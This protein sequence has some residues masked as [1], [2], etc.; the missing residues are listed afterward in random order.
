MLALL[1]AVALH[2]GN[3]VTPKLHQSDA[4]PLED[5]LRPVTRI[6]PTS[7]TLRWFTQTATETRVEWREGD[8][9]RTAFRGNNP[10]RRYAF[11]IINGPAGTRTVHTLTIDGLKPATRYYYR[12]WDPGAKPTR[13]EANWGA[14]GG[15]RREF[16]VST[17]APRG[18]KAIIHLPVKVLLMPNVVDVH[19]AYADPANPAPFPPKAT[20]E[21]IQKMKDEFA[22]SSRF[23][24]VNSGMRFWV[25]YEFYIDER[26]QR[27][28]P[29]PAQASGPFKGL[30]VSRSY[31]GEDYKQPGGG[32]HTI[33]DTEDPLRVTNTPVVEAFPYS[34][35][36]EVAWLQRW[37]P[38][39]KRWEYSNSG[40]GTFGVDSFPQG[41][42]S[43]SQFLGGGDAAWLATHEV[44]HGFE[45]L[46]T[47]S[48]SDREDERIVFNH[49]APRRRV[50]KAEGQ[51]EEQ[52]W[53]TSGPHGEHWDGMAYWDRTLSDAQWLRLYFGRTIAVRDADQ[54]GVPDDDPRLPLDEKRF[55]SSPRRAM[56]DGRLN[57][58]Q[59][60]MLSTWVPGPL[61]SSWI[62]PPFQAILPKPTDPDSDGDGLNDDVDPQPLYPYEPVIVNL[63]PQLDG[64]GAEWTGVP[65]AGTMRRGG[66]DFSW[67]Q[68]KDEAGYYGLLRL[69][70]PWRRI[71]VTLD[72]EGYGVYSGVG[73][74]GFELTRN[75]ANEVTVRPAF[76]GVPGMKHRA[77]T[78][79]GVTVV[80]FSLPN[81][82]EGLWY[83]TGGGREITAYLNIFDV[84]G[85]GYSVYE[86]YRGFRARMLESIGVPPVPPGAPQELAAGPGV[87]VLRPGSA[88]GLS[89]TWPVANG[90][91]RNSDVE[92]PMVIRGLN[93]LEFDLYAEIEAKS[94]G[95]LGA[96]LPGTRS[97]D[98]GQ[99][100]IAFVGGYA[101]R[102]TRLRLFGTE[103]G[104]DDTVMLPSGFRRIQLSRREGAVW[105][106]VDG[107]AVAWATDPSPK[108]IIDRLAVLGGYGGAQRVREI[109]YRVVK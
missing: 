59:K 13:R 73:V 22:I 43:R 81:R 35:Q 25:D 94:D 32:A 20:P 56:T 98:A 23:F 37:N 90:V 11:R 41:F 6:T 67:K 109:R 65:V 83:W 70:G 82:G 64:D 33:V 24:W 54:D 53:T 108:A 10:E 52:A 78:V 50:Q 75:D 29:E 45:S 40:G 96:F 91:W 107:K 8:I 51:V 39:R 68:A 4:A 79:G 26:F 21:Q 74:Q 106:L 80:E 55:G 44:H 100:Y 99:D 57:D 87:I 17:Q 104:D 77:R 15:Y 7:V 49:Y 63:H 27:W 14:G 61:Q 62:K 72:G 46:G 84:D 38:T 76:A 2:P 3:P 36:V 88:P 5:P 92:G 42:P 34:N 28:N 102:H 16:A 85:R 58:L 89:G 48:L 31:A 101:N 71:A 19:S 9:P 95:I 103:A 93:A 97:L 60:I 30:P 12:I 86:P 66:I 105:L 1:A 18:S 69:Q 47:F